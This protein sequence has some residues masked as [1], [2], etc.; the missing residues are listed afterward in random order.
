MDEALHD[1][2][3][4]E[5][6]A[7]DEASVRAAPRTAAPGAGPEPTTGRERPTGGDRPAHPAPDPLFREAAGAVLR[8]QRQR[9][10]QR[11]VDAADRA[12]VSPQYLSEVER[13]V[14]DPSSEVLEAAAAAVGLD[15]EALLL[16]V[17]QR[18][19]RTT[20]SPLVLRTIG[21]VQARAARTTM[22]LGASSAGGAVCLAA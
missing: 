12:G 5:T 14:K 3:R 22:H 13:G 2:D 7:P 11:L 6:A 8:E 19:R 21:S 9:N 16:E 15:L 4:H 10:G 18:R 1:T 20:T 17:V